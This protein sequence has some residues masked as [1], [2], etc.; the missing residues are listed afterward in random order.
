MAAHA[1]GAPPR[2]GELDSTCGLYAV[3]HT[4]TQLLPF[5]EAQT[6]ELYRDIVAELDPGLCKRLLATGTVRGELLDILSAAARVMRSRGMTLRADLYKPFPRVDSI[7]NCINDLFNIHDGMGIINVVLVGVR[8]TRGGGHWACVNGAS[9]RR[10][11]LWDGVMARLD[12]DHHGNTYTIDNDFIINVYLMEDL[13]RNVEGV[14]QRLGGGGV[15]A[16]VE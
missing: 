8:F 12:Y 1:S 11:H 7:F 4:I 5:T 9:K 10:I 14:R 15:W 3:V 2:Q 6:A 16:D 13:P